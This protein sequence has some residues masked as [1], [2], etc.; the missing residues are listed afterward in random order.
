[1]PSSKTLLVVCALS[2]LLLTGCA[3]AQESITAT[4]PGFWGGLWDGLTA[5]FALIGHLLGAD[6]RVYDVYNKGAFYDWGFL[7]GLGFYAA[8]AARAARNG[9]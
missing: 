1:M 4:G 7:A 3:P 6:W 8:A 2:L 5:W 9:S